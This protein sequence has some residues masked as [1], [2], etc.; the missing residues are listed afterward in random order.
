MEVKSKKKSIIVNLQHDAIKPYSIK[1][2]NHNIAVVKGE[3]TIGY[4]T[5]FESA[6]NKVSELKTLEIVNQ[7][8]GEVF[9]LDNYLKALNKIKNVFNNQVVESMNEQLKTLR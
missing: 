8:Y 2:D 7:K 4:Y 6:L 9:P 1:V 3:S 5:N